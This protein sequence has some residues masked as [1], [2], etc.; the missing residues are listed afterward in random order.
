MLVVGVIRK[1]FRFSPY[2]LNTE[3]AALCSETPD[4]DTLVLCWG[5]VILLIRQ[6]KNQ[7]MVSKRSQGNG[8][9]RISRCDMQLFH[10]S[11]S[12]SN[13]TL[14]YH[15]RPEKFPRPERYQRMQRRPM[16]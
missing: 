3:K 15:Q 9:V 10:G 7:G 8:L 13:K 6:K 11:E 4:E 1:W 16:S 14:P 5:R 12:C 2:R